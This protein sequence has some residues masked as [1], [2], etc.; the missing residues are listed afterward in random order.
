MNDRG[1]S[2]KQVEEY[3]NIKIDAQFIAAYTFI[4]KALI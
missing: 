3:K 1:W 2:W 4:S